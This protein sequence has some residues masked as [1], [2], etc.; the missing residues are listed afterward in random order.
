MYYS[1]ATW[2]IGHNIPCPDERVQQAA[3]QSPHTTDQ[4]D[5]Q[6]ARGHLQVAAGAGHDDPGEVGQADSKASHHA[7][8]QAD[9]GHSA[10]GALANVTINLLPTFISLA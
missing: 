9:K 3:Q 4:D 10:V 1:T 8:H 6:L 7:A 2:P 5:G